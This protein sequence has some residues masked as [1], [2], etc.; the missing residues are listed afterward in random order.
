MQLDKPTRIFEIIAQIIPNGV[1]MYFGAKWTDERSSWMTCG[2]KEVDMTLQCRYLEGKFIE[3]RN[4]KLVLDAVN[5][6]QTSLERHTEE[7]TLSDCDSYSESLVSNF[8]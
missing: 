4:L 1:R 5:E 7:T 2:V 3:P 8:V 6:I